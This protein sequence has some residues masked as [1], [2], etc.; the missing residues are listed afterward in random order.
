[1]LL[2]ILGTFITLDHSPELPST[3][4]ILSRKVYCL[5]FAL[6]F[7]LC[8]RRGGWRGKKKAK[9]KLLFLYEIHSPGV[10]V[11]NDLIYQWLPCYLHCFRRVVSACDWAELFSR[12]ERGAWGP[13]R[14]TSVWSKFMWNFP[15][16]PGESLFMNCNK[17]SHFDS[18]TPVHRHGGEGEVGGRA[19]VGWGGVHR[20]SVCR[21]VRLWLLLRKRCGKSQRWEAKERTKWIQRVFANKKWKEKIK[22]KEVWLEMKMGRVFH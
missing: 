18:V 4:L 22:L 6:Y 16:P 14:L 9:S 19:W 13:G 2:F 7:Q 3:P 17:K 15:G 21:D 20:V 12:V 8:C 5:F 10:R 1:M 11:N